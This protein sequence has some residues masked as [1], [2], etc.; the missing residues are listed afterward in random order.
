LRE[1][2]PPGGQGEAGELAR[3]TVREPGQVGLAE[4]G[5][6]EGAYAPNLR[7][8]EL[9]MGISKAPITRTCT[10]ISLS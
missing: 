1:V 8:K 9:Y 7:A 5:E 4:D 2:G 6:S 10:V 3:N